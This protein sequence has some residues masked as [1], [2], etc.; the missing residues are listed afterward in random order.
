MYKI[1]NISPLGNLNCSQDVLK[2]IF[3]YKKN[4]FAIGQKYPSGGPDAFTYFFSI[5]N[6]PI[7]NY[8]RG[9]ISIGEPTA[10]NENIAAL[11]AYINYNVILELELI[12]KEIEDIKYYQSKNWAIGEAYPD[13][14]PDSFVVF[15][16]ERNLPIKPYLRGTVSI[17][18]PTAY[19]ENIDILSYYR[20]KIESYFIVL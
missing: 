16:A 12:D 3:Y 5:R 8:L 15:F 14:G 17:G 4:N 2:E 20:D 7:A 1:P 13:G 10:Y 18:E 6:I 19:C 9:T 11:S